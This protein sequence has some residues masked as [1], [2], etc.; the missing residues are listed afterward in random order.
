MSANRSIRV[1]PK[2]SK[3]I[4]YIYGNGYL[5]SSKTVPKNKIVSEALSYGLRD[6]CVIHNI[7]Y[8]TFVKEQGIH[9]PKVTFKQ[10]TKHAN[11][12][13]SKRS[14]KRNNKKKKH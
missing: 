14:N 5:G 12:H 8:K 2:L 13:T 7:K 6:Y 4:F 10:I 3:F 1:N 11:K 9:L